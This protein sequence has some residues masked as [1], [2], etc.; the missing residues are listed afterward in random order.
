M[1]FCAELKQAEI[2]SQ[3]EDPEL[4]ELRNYIAMID[5]QNRRM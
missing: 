5:P 1:D 4:R 2:M 3:I